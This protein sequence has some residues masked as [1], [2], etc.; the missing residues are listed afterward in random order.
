MRVRLHTHTV[1][2]TTHTYTHNLRLK[3]TLKNCETNSETSRH[4]HQRVFAPYFPPEILLFYEWALT[5]S[6]NQWIREI[7]GLFKYVKPT[8]PWPLLA[9]F[10][11]DNL[12]LLMIFDSLDTE[13]WP[14]FSLH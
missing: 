13:E 10:L 7:G 11:Y 3:K 8:K 12:N 2:Y 1:I 14:P 5:G 9:I 4:Y 6:W